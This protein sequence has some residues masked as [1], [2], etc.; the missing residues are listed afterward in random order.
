MG[1]TRHFITEGIILKT[2][3]TGEINRNF[4]FISPVL[5][6]KTATAY[7]ASK[8]KSRFCS[9][10]QPLVKAKLYLYKPQKSD[11]YKLVDAGNVM[12]NDFIRKNLNYIYLTSFY[13]EVFLS[14]YIS[15]EEYKNYYF[16]LLYSLELLENYN[17]AVK[18]FLFFTS[19][20][21]FLSG[22]DFNL[23]ACH[24]CGKEFTKYYFDYS[25]GG[26]FCETHAEKKRIRP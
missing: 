24:A 18:S 21:L 2:M 16:L 4:L 3:H 13:C 1:E 7:G 20:F 25:Q 19:K 15:N 10:I 22:L 9:V 5:G 12:L 6:I 8:I 14:S 17:D 11:Y 23:N 26:I